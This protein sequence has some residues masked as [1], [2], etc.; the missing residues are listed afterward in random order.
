MFYL[1][2]QVCITANSYQ[3]IYKETCRVWS[4]HSYM[5]NAGTQNICLEGNFDNYIS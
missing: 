5:L 1:I 3:L 2:V 4:M